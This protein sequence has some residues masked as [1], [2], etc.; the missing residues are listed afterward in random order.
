M[1]HIKNRIAN[2]YKYGKEKQKKQLKVRKII[3]IPNDEGEK[4]EFDFKT[5]C[6]LSYFI[7]CF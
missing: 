5:Y 2:I 4:K 6:F 3:S 1:I 7:L